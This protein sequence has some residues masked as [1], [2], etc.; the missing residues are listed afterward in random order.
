MGDSTDGPFVNSNSSLQFLNNT[1]VMRGKHAFR[2]GG[3][4]RR[5]QYNQ[6]GNQYGR[7]SFSFSTTPTRDPA[8]SS[9]GYAFASFFLGTVSLTELAVSIASVQYRQPGFALCFYDFWKITPKLTF[10]LRLPYQT[11]PPS[12]NLP[13]NS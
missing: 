5:D 13:A 1:S 9:Q 3:E 8:T 4:I 12:T 10:P 7:G 11:T 2:F 6:V